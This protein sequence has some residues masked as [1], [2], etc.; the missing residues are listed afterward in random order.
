M[1]ILIVDDNEINA[2]LLAQTLKVK[3]YS[4]I[5]ALSGAEALAVLR[6]RTDIS[7]V[8]ADIMMP[9][10]DGL[11]LLQKIKEEWRD[12]PVIMCSAVTDLD[13]VRQA[14]MLGCD[15]YIVKPVDRELL[16]QK[17]AH[18]LKPVIGAEKEIMFEHQMDYDTY[19]TLARSFLKLL[20][21]ESGVLE[22]V[23]K[24]K[25]PSPPFQLQRVA[26]AASLM[27]AK[28]LQSRVEDVLDGQVNNMDVKLELGRMLRDMQQVASVLKDRLDPKK[29]RARL[30]ENEG[31]RG[32]G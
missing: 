6:D 15:S 22:E 32:A 4:S 26:E 23:I 21:E 1:N 17:I 24:S 5:R 16:V 25:T 20:E 8:L 28:Q 14:V 12:L 7:L 19:L 27:G 18:A 10:M 2:I 11:E 9:E 30:T 29:I 31:L 3:G 13:R